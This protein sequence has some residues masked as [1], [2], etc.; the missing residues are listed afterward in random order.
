MQVRLDALVEQSTAVLLRWIA[1]ALGS[2]FV[3][4]LL[5]AV[6]GLWLQQRAERLRP[7]ATPAQLRT[8]IPGASTAP[9]GATR[10]D[11]GRRDTTRRDGGRRD[12][13]RRDSGR[14]DSGPVRLVVVEPLSV[15]FQQSESPETYLLPFVRHNGGDARADLIL[16][17]YDCL[18]YT[19]PS[20]RDGLLSRMPSSA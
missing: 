14:Q 13:T 9:E 6:T 2:L 18:L 17:S 20:P 10:R 19:S 3:L 8:R 5:L 1:Y 11:G 16:E 12:A 4:S 7:Q 15:L